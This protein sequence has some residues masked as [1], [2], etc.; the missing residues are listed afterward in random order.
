MDDET[1]TF[2]T[3][4]VNSVKKAMGYKS[5]IK[6]Y[7][8]SDQTLNAS[9]IQSGD[10]VV[11]AGAIIQ[12][13]NYKEL[14]A[15]LAHEVGHIEGR[16]IQLFMSNMKDFMKAGLVPALIGG[17]IS[18]IAGNPAPLMAGAL[19]G[20]SISQGMALG[21]L[22]QKEEI[23]DTKAAEALKKLGW[24]L[25]DGCLDMHKKLANKSFVYNE[26]L[27]THPHSSKRIAKYKQYYDEFKNKP[28]SEKAQNLMKKYETKFETVK[29]KLHALVISNE[30]LNELYKTP[31]D[32]NEKYARAVALYRLNRYQEAIKLI[33]ELPST[34]KEQSAY[35]GE[36]KCMAMIN[37]KQSKEAADVAKKLLQN[38]RQIKEHR[39]LVV[40][41]AEAINSGNIKAQAENAIKHL[42]RVLTPKDD[43]ISALHEL[44][45]LYIMTNHPDRAS[46]CAAQTAFLT[47]DNKMTKIHA[48]RATNSADPIIRRKAQDILISVE[49]ESNGK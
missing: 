38:T 10:I 9:A 11:N 35:Y 1:E 45:R 31:K 12:S 28:L 22:R 20:Q 44:G 19:S 43:D 49:N 13:A 17:A 32:N 4:V 26:Y 21:K 24:Y 34:D 39:D 29:K 18:V 30:F 42:K 33:D 47:G 37:L 16:H 41:Y 23:A 2:L 15:I 25:F 46:Y 27:S 6:V 36:I 8:S 14:I 3:E 48:K 5:E 40:I 7:I